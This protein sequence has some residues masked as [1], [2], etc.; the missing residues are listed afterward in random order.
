MDLFWEG[1]FSWPKFEDLNGLPKIPEKPSIYLWTLDYHDGYIIYSAGITKSPK[2][3]FQ[4]HTTAY[5]KGYYNT[6]NLAQ[7]RLGIRDIIWRWTA[8]NKWTPERKLD[9]QKRN[10]MGE[11][12]DLLGGFRVFTATMENPRIRARIEASV[13]L[14]L[15]RA[16]EPFCALPDRGMHLEPKWKNEK[17]ILVKNVCL[18]RLHGLPDDML[19]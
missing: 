15:Y 10:I 8:P 4:A 3:R 11:I 13:I 17:S 16:P 19:I 6:L 9:F 18:A 2:L 12:D 7:A 5:R 1:P 14:N